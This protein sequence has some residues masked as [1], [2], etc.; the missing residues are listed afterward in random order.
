ML[1]EWSSRAR[2]FCT[3]HE[4]E[5]SSSLTCRVTVDDHLPGATAP[6]TLCDGRNIVLDTSRMQATTCLAYRPGYKCDGDPVFVGYGNSAVSGYCSRTDAF[7]L[8]SFPRDHLRDI[9]G[10]WGGTDAGTLAAASTPSAPI[11][12][13]ITRER[14]EHANLFH[15]STDWVNAF[16]TLHA[17]GV[18]DGTD[19]E[20]NRVGM[21][22]VQVLLLDSQTGPFDELFIKRVL[23]PKHPVLRI[24]DLQKRGIL[25]LRIPHALFVPPGYTNFFLAHVDRDSTCHETSRLLRAFRAFVLNGMDLM[26]P[27]AVANDKKLVVTFI[28]RRPYNT[29]GVQHGSLGR[30]IDNEEEVL[31][32]LASLPNVS[33]KRYDFALQ[34][35]DEQVRLV[36][37]TD[38]L[39]SMHGAGL[40]SM[41]YMP[42]HGA[43]LELWPKA[44][45]MWRV[46][47]HI[48]ALS[49][50][51]YYRWENTDTSAFRVDDRGD[52]TR[53]DI[54]QFSALAADAVQHVR[55][56][57]ER[58]AAVVPLQ[59]GSE[60]LPICASPSA[61]PGPKADPLSILPPWHPLVA[62]ARAGVTVPLSRATKKAFIF[63]MD[64]LSSWVAQSKAGGPAGER[65]VREGLT[66]ALE[67]LGYVV[68]TADSDN[69]MEELTRGESS[70]SYDLFFFDPW[71]VQGRD[72]RPR[73]Y[74]AGKEDRLFI[75]AFFGWDPAAG[76]LLPLLPQSHVLTAFP[77]S[78]MFAANTF[79]GFVQPLPPP[80][81]AGVQS[82]RR[83]DGVVWAKN[84]NYLTGRADLLQNLLE[85]P[86][87]LESGMRL[88][89]VLDNSHAASFFSAAP[90]AV[91]RRLVWHGHLPSAEWHALLRSSAFLI[92]LGNPLLGPS[93]LDALA[94]G[95]V[96]IDP[97]Y[98]GG[99]QP[100]DMQYSVLGSQHPYLRSA[101]GPPH[102]CAANLELLETVID[103]ILRAQADVSGLGESGEVLQPLLLQD[104][105]QEAVADRVR[106][107][108]GAPQLSPLQS[109]APAPK[110]SAAGFKGHPVP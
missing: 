86:R 72:S 30:Q 8:E 21:E 35:F 56:E 49:G 87:L 100:S 7:T 65:I 105:K 29:F 96:Y 76:G 52:Y 44:S 51:G 13:L 104:F 10:S 47:E 24:P 90:D 83:I 73:A 23:S 22:N 14:G 88:H 75:L 78:A 17:S 31:L 34:P 53:V 36:A 109:G 6:H 16:M 46:F 59:P 54:G 74:L 71:T 106:R 85:H 99:V 39:I 48:A 25:S 98:S 91:R 58:K 18:I 32:A 41:L 84:G 80:A 103:C 12:L 1:A 19:E 110:V 27:A 79:L 67:E 45:D 61:V 63:T 69:A 55:A 89:F 97:D 38:V 92:G 70:N 37:N 93:A 60:A 9:F 2:A 81:G 82:A 5:E 107:S 33:V 28:S 57:L 50:L 101:V 20:S 15:S 3:A 62:G 64:S 77:P 66:A 94:A 43:V 102:V 108:I 68:T 4:G 26:P 42:D 95:A 40:T 11:V